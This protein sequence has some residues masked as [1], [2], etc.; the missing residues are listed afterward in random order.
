MEARA[1]S[2]PTSAGNRVRQG[3][4][5]ILPF[6]LAALAL[7]P[8]RD[9]LPTAVASLRKAQPIA[10][11]S[12]PFF[13]V[14]NHLATLAWRALLRGAGANPVALGELVRVRIEAQ[15]VN[16]LVPT[17]GVAGE[18]L[19]AFRAAGGRNLAAA[20]L[21]TFL[22]NVAGLVSGLVFAGCAFALHLQTRS[23]GSMIRALTVSVAAA[24]ALLIVAAIL[25][26]YL[27]P[28][29]LPRL[30]ATSRL[31]AVIEPFADRSL[32]I[33]HTFRTA[34]GLR[35]L[36][37]VVAVG[38]SYAVFHAVGAPVSI[39]GAALVS[40]VLVAVSFVAFFSPGQLGAAE[41]ATAVIGV[42]LGFPA[43]L[44]LSAALL[45]RVRQLVVCALGLISIMAR[46][47]ERSR[48][49]TT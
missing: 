25:L 31:R 17:A 47:F 5:R 41:A 28:R 13:F 11:L 3:A 2:L 12:L 16:Q 4:L 38:E 19:R 36:E 49:R 22:D 29:W 44:G 21:A 30:P 45:R 10:L 18:A 24:L 8:F 32:D 23:G 33:R 1:A 40:G 43:A 26:L 46:S 9:Q 35:F 48:T 34:V 27:G 7:I 6:V 20:S 37:R 42:V 15:A 14:W 39:A